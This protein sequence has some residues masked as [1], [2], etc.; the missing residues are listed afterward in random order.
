VDA[1]DEKVLRE[2]PSMEVM[3]L[4]NSLDNVMGL[5]GLGVKQSA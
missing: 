4:S 5:K 3:H 2:I 1:T